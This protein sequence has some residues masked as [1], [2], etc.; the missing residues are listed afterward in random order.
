MQDTPC[1]T[2]THSSQN[3]SI[4]SEGGEDLLSRLRLLEYQIALSNDDKS[5]SSRQ[6]KELHDDTKYINGQ[7]KELQ[8]DNKCLKGDIKYL[9]E[10]NNY[11]KEQLQSRSRQIKELEDYSKYVKREL[12]LARPSQRTAAL[13]SCRAADE[14]L[15]RIIPEMI[16]GTTL[17]ISR[18][19]RNE[20]NSAA[21]NIDIEI[22]IEIWV[23]RGITPIPSIPL[24]DDMVTFTIIFGMNS[25]E[26]AKFACNDDLMNVFKVNEVLNNHSKLVLNFAIDKFR[27]RYSVWLKAARKYSNDTDIGNRFANR[28]YKDLE[29]AYQ[30]D[31]ESAKE[32]WG[33]P[34]KL[35]SSA[36]RSRRDLTNHLTEHDRKIVIN[37]IRDTVPLKR[38][39]V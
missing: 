38:V 30:D 17:D 4:Y 9:K 36:L 10:D 24:R 25:A 14:L 3:I 23:P 35:G 1:T 32:W 16:Q 29:D 2:K 13:L 27:A 20:N 28:L 22:A 12:Q 21:H 33:D 15:K 6:L 19:S 18:E 11:L 39:W 5:S 8:V 31:R 7:I 34:N 37:E 26:Y